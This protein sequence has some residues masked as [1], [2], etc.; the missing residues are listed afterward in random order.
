MNKRWVTCGLKM[1]LRGSSHLQYFKYFC[2][3]SP[4]KFVGIITVVVITTIFTFLNI[5]H[6]FNFFQNAKPTKRK[7]RNREDERF[8]S[9]VEQYKKKLV[10]NLNAKTQVKKSKWFGWACVC[11]RERMSKTV[12]CQKSFLIFDI[13]WFQKHISVRKLKYLTDCVALLITIH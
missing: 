3:L 1:S 11:A 6:P 10:G 12:C 5:Y 9:L 2:N 8:D 4:V 7:V 13:V